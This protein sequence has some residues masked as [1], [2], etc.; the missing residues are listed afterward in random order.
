MEDVF[1]TALTEAQRSSDATILVFREL[2]DLPGSVRREHLRARKRIKM[3]QNLAWQP[4]PTR[5]LL[6]GLTLFL[7]PTL[8]SLLKLLFGYLPLINQIGS[9]I[10]I[11]LLVYMLVVL[12]YGLKRGF[13]RWAIPCLGVA[14]TGLV[15]LGPSRRI[16]SLFASDV[17]RAIGYHAKTLQVRVLY[18]ALMGGFFYALAFLSAALLILFLMVWPRTRQLAQRIRTDWTLF[19]FM[20]F[21]G[22]VFQLELIFE[23]YAYDELWK[24]ACRA[25]LALG[26]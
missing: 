25:C 9:L 24:I 16:W 8:P 11:A 20:F 15:I 10:T 22:L 23:E 21:G 26:A 17:Q 3:D 7:L 2:R 5:E 12:V 19:S 1:A 18:Q 4:P 6:T 13:P 14:V